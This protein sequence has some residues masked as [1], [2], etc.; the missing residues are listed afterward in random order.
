MFDMD[1]KQLRKDLPE[2]LNA[3]TPPS[4]EKDDAASISNRELV[5]QHFRAEIQKTNVD[6]VV[7]LCW[8][9]TGLLDGTIFNGM[10]IYQRHDY[11]TTKQFHV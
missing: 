2:S 10:T 7:L 6:I 1:D 8:F 11:T 3:S 5:S 4:Y 9:V